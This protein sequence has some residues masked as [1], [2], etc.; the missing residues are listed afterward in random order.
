[1]NETTARAG[2]FQSSDPIENL[3]AS[4]VDCDEIRLVVRNDGATDYSPDRLRR[5]E[6]IEAAHRGAPWRRDSRG[7]R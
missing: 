4:P 2:T 6:A 7:T 5:L 1:M 3:L